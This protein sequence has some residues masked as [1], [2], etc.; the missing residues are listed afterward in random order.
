MPM[1]MRFPRPPYV[2]R[3]KAQQQ[4]VPDHWL[5]FEVA[6]TGCGIGPEGL[7]SL[8]KEFVQ[9]HTASKVRGIYI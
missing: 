8:F 9:V 6:D 5:V 1:I 7:Q 2:C 3:S 4:K